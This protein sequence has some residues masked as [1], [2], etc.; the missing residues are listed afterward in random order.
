[1]LIDFSCKK[2]NLSLLNYNIRTILLNS[3]SIGKINFMEIKRFD[4]TSI[5]SKYYSYIRQNFAY[6]QILDDI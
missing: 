5:T 2:N 1:M 4:I 6:I 3:Y